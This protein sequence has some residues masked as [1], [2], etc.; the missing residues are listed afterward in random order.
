MIPLSL[1][2]QTL[3]ADLAQ[4]V[5]DDVRALSVHTKTVADGKYLYAREKIGRRFRDRALGPSDSPDAQNVA[6]QLRSAGQRAR[7]RRKL[8]TLIKR[9]GVPAPS[10]E[11]SRLIE[12]ISGSGLFARG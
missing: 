6:D 4:S 5:N 11:M 8:V 7:A 9:S 3:I 2:I 12:A 1:N 10:T